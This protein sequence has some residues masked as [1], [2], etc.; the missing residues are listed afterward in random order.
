MIEVKWDEKD[1]NITFD[2]TDSDTNDLGKY[3]KARKKPVEVSVLQMPDEFSVQTKEGNSYKAKKGD[4]LIVGVEGEPY[5]CDQ[6]I[7]NKT[8]DKVKND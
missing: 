5:P 4:Y 8:Y 7:F 2:L 3:E 6:Q 1:N